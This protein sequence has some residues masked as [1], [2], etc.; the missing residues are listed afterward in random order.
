MR[1]RSDISLKFKGSVYFAASRSVLLCGCKTQS[2]LAEDV[3][4]L[5]VFDYRFLRSIDEF[6][7]NG[8]VSN[9]KVRNRVSPT[10]LQRILSQGVQQG[11]LC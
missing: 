11:K 2:F 9:A 4:L 5:E 7:C 10:G 8:R 3:L 1:S 6:G